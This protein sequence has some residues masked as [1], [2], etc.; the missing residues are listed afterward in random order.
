[1]G[2]IKHFLKSPDIKIR[3]KA[4][5]III[6]VKVVPRSSKTMIDGIYHGV[7]KIRLTSPPVDNAANRDLIAFLSQKLKVP[8][9]AVKIIGGAKSREKRLALTGVEKSDILNLIS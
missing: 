3:K 4:D 1:M 5:G 6:Q 2:T 7:L 9:S 8:K